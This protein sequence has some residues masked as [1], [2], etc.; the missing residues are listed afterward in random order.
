M[1]RTPRTRT[2]WVTVAI[3]LA[4][5]C[6]TATGC[7]DPAP[8]PTQPIASPTTAPPA[9]EEITAEGVLAPPERATNAYTYDSALAPE[10]SGISV[11]AGEAGSSTWV[12]LQVQ[13]L[14]PNRGYAAHAHARAC[15]AT[16]DAAGP[17]YQHV[18]DPAA[19]PEKP[20]TDPAYANPRNEI[21]LDLHTDGDGNAELR[22]EA[23]FTFTDRAPGSVVVHSHEHTATAPGQAGVA[24]AR[25]ACLTVPF[26]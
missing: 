1:T 18:V 6:T 13:G 20:S 12:R 17:H 2:Q 5:V 3:A 25:I 23:P 22:T 21:W 11:A 14:M 19:T 7:G 8:A 24:G 4:A 16:G 15:G 9:L 26:N 10:G